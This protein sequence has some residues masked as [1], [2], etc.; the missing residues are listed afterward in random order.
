MVCERR[1]IESYVA[2]SRR[3]AQRRILLGARHGCGG[4]GHQRKS[5]EKKQKKK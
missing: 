3:I 2:Q 1:R 5:E 4:K